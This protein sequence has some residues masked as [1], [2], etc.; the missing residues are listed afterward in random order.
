MGSWGIGINWPHVA[1][2]RRWLCLWLGF[3]AF[4]LVVGWTLKP[5][6]DEILFMLALPALVLVPYAVGCFL[7]SA[8]RLGLVNLRG[9][10]ASIVTLTRN[11]RLGKR[12][13]TSADNR[14]PG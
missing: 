14:L 3:V 11:K 8:I 1:L 9:R 7:V 2:W 4:G 12:T 13:R 5:R 10:N 6:P